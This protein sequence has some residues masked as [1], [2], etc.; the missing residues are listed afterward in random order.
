M[1]HILFTLI[2]CAV[3]AASSS[4]KKCQICTA[5]NAGL[6]EDF[7]FA[8][9][10]IITVNSG[11]ANY[12]GTVYYQGDQFTIIYNP[13]DTS[14]INNGLQFYGS[15]SVTRSIQDTV[16]GRGKPYKDMVDEHEKNDWY[17]SEYKKSKSD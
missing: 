15:A 1:K 14:L 10:D 9:G 13:E 12:A 4:C 3:V 2:V 7:T 6:T 17:C 11:D 8:N 16:C 5:D